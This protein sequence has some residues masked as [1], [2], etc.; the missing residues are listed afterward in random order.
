MYESEI[1]METLPP[2]WRKLFTISII[3][4]RVLEPRV[5]RWCSANKP[6]MFDCILTYRDSVFGLVKGLHLSSSGG[7]AFTPERPFASFWASFPKGRAKG[8]A[9]GLAKGH[10]ERA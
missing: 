9:K 4:F 1:M 5:L 3:F 8:R 10:C 7:I 6:L 2:L